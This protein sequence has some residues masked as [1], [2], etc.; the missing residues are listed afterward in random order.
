MRFVSLVIAGALVA[1]APAQ[2]FVSPSGSDVTGTGSQANPYRTIGFAAGQANPGA[3]INLTAGEFGDDDQIVLG[4]RDLTLVGAGIGATIVRPHA[5]LTQTFPAGQLPGTPT[6][7]TVVIAVDGAARVDLRGMTID[8]AFRV[9]ASGRLYG[10]LYRDGASGTVDGVEIVN[11]RDDPLSNSQSPAAAVVR[12]DGA[13]PSQV[14]FRQ[15][16]IADFGKVGIAAFFSALVDVEYCEVR[17]AGAVAGGGP[18]QVGVQIGFGAVGAVNHNIVSD[19]NDPATP[20][21]SSGVLL[22]NAGAGCRVEANSVARCDD[23][24]AVAQQPPASVAG[25]VRSNNASAAF[26][27]ALRVEGQSPLLITGNVASHVES[28]LS[29]VWDDTAGLNTWQR[30]R[31]SDFLSGETYPIPGGANV[32]PAPVRGCAEFAP[33]VP[34]NLGFFAEDVVIADFDGL[35]QLD[36]AAVRRGASPI[37]AVA[38][39]NGAGGYTVQSLPFS[40]GA[41]MAIDVVAGQ[42]DAM[43][44]DDL[45]VLTR[46]V[47]TTFNSEERFYLFAND[48]SGTFSLTYQQKLPPAIFATNAIASGDLNGDG[49][50]DL[51][52]GSS[53]NGLGLPGIGLLMF[54]S[55]SLSS[56]APGALPGISQ[57]VTAVAVADIDGAAGVDIVVLEATTPQ[58]GMRFYTNDGSGSFVEGAGSPVLVGNTPT[59]VTTQDIDGD[60][61]R[62]VIA[63]AWESATGVTPGSV[64]I[65]TND[66]PTGFGARSVPTDRGPVDVVGGDIAFD[67]DPDTLRFDSVVANRL[68]NSLTLVMEHASGGPAGGPLCTRGAGPTGVAVGDL[69]GDGLQDALVSAAGRVFVS[70][71]YGVPTSREDVYGF[72]CPGTAGRSPTIGAGGNPGVALVG[73]S[74]FTIELGDTPP[75]APAAFLLSGAPSP[76]LFPCGL[77]I[78]PILFSVGVP[79]SPAGEFT[80]PLP[81]PNNPNLVG[82][83]FYN[84]WAVVDPVGPFLNFL[85]LTQGLKVRVGA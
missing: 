63:T 3:V 61:D 12:G 26:D 38:L 28:V 32:D 34:V 44:G 37:L 84:Q 62:D 18:A 6:E 20:G 8:G 51:V 77:H 42:F 83:T 22:F 40:S 21:S 15:C 41:A 19:C 33:S 67:S 72:G 43:P 70:I 76:A 78:G 47:D 60:G 17:G 36:F 25:F 49:F 16:R 69:D 50:E 48:G 45:V 52:I 65:L 9:P 59:A 2:I 58:G 81:V 80:L 30:N 74:N 35:N 85:T 53:G 23:G 7:H 46:N 66:L 24:I 57:P 79:T 64:W 54:N 29:P 5:T 1:S 68:G 10:V 73:N 75:S 4:D 82:A 13:G 14:R 27:Q 55:G 56:W 31:Y 39:E 11:T 71:L